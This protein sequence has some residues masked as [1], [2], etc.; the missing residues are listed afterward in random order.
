MSH[1]PRRPPLWAGYLLL[2]GAVAVACLLTSGTLHDAL[3]AAV[4]CSC[5]VAIAVGVR[6]HRPVQPGAWWAMAAG[7]ACWGVGD[8]SYVLVYD[9]GG[10]QA[11]PAPPDV[12]YLLAY[13]LLGLSLLALARKARPGRDVEG[14]IDAT[15]LAVGAGLLSWVF[16]LAPALQT[17]SDDLLGGAVSAAYPVADVFVLAML[18]RL[19]SAAGARS[20]S[21]VMLCA[22]AVSMLVADA[23][24]QLAYAAVGYDGSA[25]DPAWLV[26]YLLWGACALHPSMRRLSDPGPGTGRGELGGGRLLLL[27]GAS[28]LA[29]ATLTLQL[30][31]QRHPSSWAVAITSAVLFLL[32]VAR[33]W[34]L[35]RRLRVQAEQLSAL[36]RTDPLTGL[37]NR[38]SGDAVLQRMLSRCAQEG[39]DLVVVLLDLDHFKAFND[40]HGHPAGDRLLVGAARAWGEVLAGT[41]AQLARWGGEEFLVVLAGVDRPAVEALLDR[42]RDVVPEGRTFSAGAARRD[43]GAGGDVATLVAT[44]DEAL[45]AAK[46]AG[47]D[48]TCWA[49]DPVA[50]AVAPD[51]APAVPLVPAVP[52]RQVRRSAEPAQRS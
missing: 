19:T 9:V 14:V 15:I 7:M 50:T 22:A 21:F 16:L 51:A 5:A 10:S 4:S 47:R 44:A 24:Y 17:L 8:V 49:P 40:T 18:V 3:L 35:L 25:L 12:A 37:L 38:R 42:M 20:P 1:V 26:G 28:L 31:L 39:S 6:V 46:A 45:Y 30:L 29:P 2:G 34:T 32:V 27:A 23:S 41:G 36:A 43:P 52:A 48:R 13:P 11:Y 33:M